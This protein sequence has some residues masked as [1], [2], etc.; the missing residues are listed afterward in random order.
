MEALAEGKEPPVAQ[1]P[2]E[3]LH[4]FSFFEFVLEFLNGIFPLLLDISFSFLFPFFSFFLI[5]YKL[6]KNLIQEMKT[7]PENLEKDDFHEY[8]K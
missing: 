1:S 3:E 5:F 6:E 7:V 2:F 4:E 8:Y